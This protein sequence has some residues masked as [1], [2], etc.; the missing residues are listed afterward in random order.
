M[1]GQA[2]PPWDR[3]I[4]RRT[5]IGA[6]AAEAALMLLVLGRVF[7]AALAGWVVGHSSSHT[8]T[9]TVRKGGVVSSAPIDPRIAAR[10]APKHQ[11][12]ILPPRKSHV[13]GFVA[14]GGDILVQPADE[15]DRNRPAARRAPSRG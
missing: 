4:R 11:V 5:D 8:K 1:R 12:A 14:A 7:V 13:T 15:L 9:I 6:A 10:L 3:P 2:L